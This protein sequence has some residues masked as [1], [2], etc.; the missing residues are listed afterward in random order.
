L[1]RLPCPQIII[2]IFFILLK[3]PKVYYIKVSGTPTSGTCTAKY[4]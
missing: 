2:P 3:L 1:E 4:Q